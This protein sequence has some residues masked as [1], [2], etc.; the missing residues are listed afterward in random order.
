MLKRD[1]RYREEIIYQILNSARQP[2]TR[3][4]LIYGSLLS[5]NQL[6]QYI[7]LLI[8]NGMLQFDPTS[9]RMFKITEEGRKF[10]RLYESIRE[11]TISTLDNNISNIVSMNAWTTKGRSIA[12]EYCPDFL[13]N[14]LS[15]PIPVALFFAAS[16]YPHHAFL[17]SF[18]LIGKNYWK[19]LIT[20]ILRHHI[21]IYTSQRFNRLG[22]LN[23][24]S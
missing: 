11:M 2:V 1:R 8:R 22:F 12:K 20:E 3:T 10:L 24:R 5:N 14:C 6:R 9:T 17:A 13:F 18:S 7:I 15:I 21:H 4:R 23:E 19:H 16:L